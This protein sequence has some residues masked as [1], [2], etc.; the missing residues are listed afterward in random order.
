MK[1]SVE[2]QSLPGVNK[3]FSRD[4]EGESTEEYPM[5]YREDGSAS[6]VG[7]KRVV[8]RVGGRSGSFVLQYSGTFEGGIAKATL[9]CGTVVR[10]R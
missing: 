6:F 7:L 2:R 10:V 4:I 8:G 5:V 3:F 1:R 9:V